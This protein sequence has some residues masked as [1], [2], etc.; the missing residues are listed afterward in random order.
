MRKLT[1]IAL[2]VAGLG[3]TPAATAETYL[4]SL[5][6]GSSA[7]DPPWNNWPSHNPPGVGATLTLDDLE[8]AF[9][10]DTRRHRALAELREEMQ[11]PDGRVLMK[12][13][14]LSDARMIDALYEAQVRLICTAAAEPEYLYVEGDGAFEFERTASRLR[15]M[16]DKDWG[17]DG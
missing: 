8:F 15:E 6:R 4:L 1:A 3:L 12:V 13:N 2:L 9:P 7:A 10:E 16:Q 17:Q 5:G 11:H 14:N